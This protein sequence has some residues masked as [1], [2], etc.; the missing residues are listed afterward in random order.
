MGA[1]IN[2][3]RVLNPDA[4]KE[5]KDLLESC[6]V[7]ADPWALTDEIKQYKNKI[8]LTDNTISFAD[9]VNRY[10]EYGSILDWFQDM[11]RVFVYSTQTCLWH[12]KVYTDTQQIKGQK[13]YQ[14]NMCNQGKIR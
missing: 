13:T 7:Q 9:V 3:I 2:A 6:V 10:K 14:L 5:N 12:Y 11:Q 4:Y 8:C 1:L